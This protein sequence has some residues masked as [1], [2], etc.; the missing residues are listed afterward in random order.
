MSSETL[1]WDALASPEEI[2]LLMEAGFIYRYVRRFHEA[3]EVF[4]GV[5]ALRPRNEIPEIALGTVSFEEGDFSNAIG[6]YTKAIEINPRSAYAY[7]HL[8]EAQLLRKDEENARISLKRA[9]ELDPNSEFG[10]LARTLLAYLGTGRHER[11]L[12]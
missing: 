2:A 5:Q 1:A 7:A 11:T 9:L 4:R 12:P 10:N 3:R 6:H 8:G